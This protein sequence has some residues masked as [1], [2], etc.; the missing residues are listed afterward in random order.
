[1]HNK[2]LIITAVLKLS[3]QPSILFHLRQKKIV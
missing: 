3:I 1:M 2:P